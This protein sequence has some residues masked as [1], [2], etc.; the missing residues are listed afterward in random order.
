MAT[1]EMVDCPTCGDKTFEVGPCFA[2]AAKA[3]SRPRLIIAMKDGV[4]TG[5]YGAALIDVIAIDIDETERR[6]TEAGVPSIACPVKV[7]GLEAIP[8]AVNNELRMLEGFLPQCGY[9]HAEFDI[10]AAVDGEYCSAVCSESTWRLAH[11]PAPAVEVEEPAAP[12]TSTALSD[13][14]NAIFD[15]HAFRMTL[16]S[17]ETGWLISIMQYRLGEISAI[18]A[19]AAE[20]FPAVIEKWESVKR[21]RTKPLASA[22]A[23]RIVQREQCETCGWR[24]GHASNCDRVTGPAIAS[25]SAT[26]VPQIGWTDHDIFEVNYPDKIQVML[27]RSESGEIDVRVWRIGDD[28]AVDHATIYLPEKT[29]CKRCHDRVGQDFLNT[30]GLCV[31]CGPSAED[32]I[33]LERLTNCLAPDYVGK[34][35][36]YIYEDYSSASPE[37]ATFIVAGP[38]TVAKLPRAD[39]KREPTFDYVLEANSDG[40]SCAVATFTNVWALAQRILEEDAK[41]VIANRI[42]HVQTSEPVF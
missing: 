28:E 12:L 39:T 20:N 29:D 41:Q 27:D 36:P 6:E 2:C 21:A 4:I 33:F 16:D 19:T 31:E 32:L 22:V 34:Q 13:T 37:G 8:N 38:W 35:E 30:E 40:D 7:E 10:E 9:C 15:D 11:P 1:E 23:S 14:A 24:E 26:H 25:P 3:A 42:E 18:P 17:N 5:V